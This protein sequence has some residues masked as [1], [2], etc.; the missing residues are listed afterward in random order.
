VV[1]GFLVLVFADFSPAVAGGTPVDLAVAQE[2]GEGQ[3]QPAGQEEEAEGQESQADEEN[4]AGETGAGESE[5]EPAAEEIG[6]PWTYQMARLGFLL[7]LVL[8]LGIGF[9]YW[10]LIARRQRTGI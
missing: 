9:W 8:G 4:T 10:R 5:T 2:T 1:I 6:P 3:E 7:L